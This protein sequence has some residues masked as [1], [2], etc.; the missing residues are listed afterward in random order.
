VAAKKGSRSDVM[1]DETTLGRIEVS[2]RAIA[3][4]AA[5]AVLTSYGVVGMASGTLRDGIAE[6]LNLEN[7]HRGVGV[8]VVDGQ[9]VVDLHVVIEYGTRISVVAHNVM[10]SVKFSVE[11]A[12]AMPV[13]EVNVH[14]QGVRVSNED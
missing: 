6:I 1:S 3:S 7:V 13:R 12:L 8:E 11:Q 10:D 2:P 9:V 4:I 5:R 14:V